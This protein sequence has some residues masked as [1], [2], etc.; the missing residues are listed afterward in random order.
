MR[1][2]TNVAGLV[3]V[4]CR[5]SVVRSRTAVPRQTDIFPFHHQRAPGGRGDG[6]NNDR[7]Q[8]KWARDTCATLEV[9]L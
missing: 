1:D 9:R 7:Q 5:G 6:G 4:M 8:N 2:V 3:S